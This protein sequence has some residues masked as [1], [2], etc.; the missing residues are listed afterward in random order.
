MP[1]IAEL[2]LS[3]LQGILSTLQS[4]RHYKN[5]NFDDALQAIKI[6][7][8]ETKKHIELG[9]RK[10]DREKEYYLAK[11]WSTASI[12]ARRAN[13]PFAEALSE[14]SRYWEDQNIWEED[15]VIAKGIKFSQI[16]EQIEELQSGS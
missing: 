13:I 11:L 3:P 1:G 5:K 4:E 9:G 7:L 15:Q 10:R 14:K 6:A 8:L 2:F 16:E 12:K